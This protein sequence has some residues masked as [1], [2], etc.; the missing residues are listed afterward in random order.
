MKPGCKRL[1]V[2]S[3]GLDRLLLLEQLDAFLDLVLQQLRRAQHR[4]H[5]GF[6]LLDKHSG[7]PSGEFSLCDG[8]QGRVVTELGQETNPCYGR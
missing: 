4:D 1:L 5:L 3:L 8:R 6:I 7:D 2:L